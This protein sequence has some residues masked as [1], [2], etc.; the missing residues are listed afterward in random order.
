MRHVTTFVITCEPGGRRGILQVDAA[1][2]GALCQIDIHNLE[3]MTRVDHPGQE[4]HLPLKENINAL[5]YAFAM[6]PSYSFGVEDRMQEAT[7]AHQ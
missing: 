4:P 1:E 7:K 6:C 5:T 2:T 3:L